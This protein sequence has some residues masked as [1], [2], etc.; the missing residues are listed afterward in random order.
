MISRRTIMTGGVLGSVGGAAVTDAT[1]ASVR[2]QE[3]DTAVI[4]R[5]IDG[6]AEELQRQRTSCGGGDCAAVDSIRQQ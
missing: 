1:S 3:L 2:A 6:I 4:V 5:A